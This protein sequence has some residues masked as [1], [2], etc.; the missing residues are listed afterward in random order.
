MVHRRHLELAWPETL[1]TE[2]PKCIHLL[3]VSY[4]GNSQRE[5]D[6]E[7]IDLNF[8]VISKTDVGSLSLCLSS[9]SPYSLAAFLPVSPGTRPLSF[10][11]YKIQQLQVFLDYLLKAAVK[12]YEKKAVLC[13][14]C[15]VAHMPGSS[16]T[17]FERR[18]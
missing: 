1:W 12:A 2:Q 3:I 16:S 11:K 17:S 6:G 5:F 8:Q 15:A 18:C 13:W 10:C 14:A 4:L 9:S 7:D